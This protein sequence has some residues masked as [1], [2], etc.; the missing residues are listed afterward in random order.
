V[1]LSLFIQYTHAGYIAQDPI[2]PLQFHKLTPLAP[3][4][5]ER[6]FRGNDAD[7]RGTNQETIEETTQE[8]MKSLSPPVFDAPP[9]FGAWTLPKIRD[10]PRRFRDIRVLF[11]QEQGELS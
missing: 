9:V 3:F 11:H 7:F 6:G 8:N 10:Y 5:R 4:E 1:F 2:L